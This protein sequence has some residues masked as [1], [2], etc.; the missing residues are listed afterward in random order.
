MIDIGF[1]ELRKFNFKSVV[2]TLTSG[3]SICGHAGNASSAGGPPVATLLVFTQPGKTLPRT[4][5]DAGYMPAAVNVFN[6]ATSIL[7]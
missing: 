1:L 2:N 7:A 6:P 4:A 5:R 3:W